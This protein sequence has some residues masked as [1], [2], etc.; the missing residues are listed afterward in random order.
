MRCIR[1][2]G[3]K[4]PELLLDGGMRVTAYRCIHCG[5]LSDEKILLHRQ[6]RLPP[7]PGKSRTPIY[8][9]HRWKRSG[10]ALV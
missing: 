7:Y 6:R 1:C 9:N 4:V 5:D 2:A 10:P 8:G 3:L